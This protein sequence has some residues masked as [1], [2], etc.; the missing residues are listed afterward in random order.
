MESKQRLFNS[1]GERKEVLNKRVTRVEQAKANIEVVTAEQQRLEQQVKLIRADAVATR[2]TEALTD[3]I[4]ASVE[5]LGE[6]NKWLSEMNDFKDV[7]GDMP[8][9]ISTRIGFG[10]DGIKTDYSGCNKKDKEIANNIVKRR[11]IHEVYN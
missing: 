7:V 3:R 11:S 6:T 10:E 4:D 1:Y 2:N 5:H 8:D 9:N